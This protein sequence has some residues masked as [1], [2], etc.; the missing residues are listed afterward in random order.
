MTKYFGIEKAIEL[1][2]GIGY[3][4]IDIAQLGYSAGIIVGTEIE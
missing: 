3:E 4:G 1:L 2:V